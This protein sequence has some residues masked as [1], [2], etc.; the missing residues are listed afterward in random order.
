MDFEEIDSA[1]NAPTLIIWFYI[2]K[3]SKSHYLISKKLMII[4]GDYLL[5]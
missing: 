4:Y 1:A 5:P 2:Q 3:I